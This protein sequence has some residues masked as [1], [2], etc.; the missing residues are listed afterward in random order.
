MSLHHLM[1][2][3]RR[4]EV[5]GDEISHFS[6]IPEVLKVTI[7]LAHLTCTYSNRRA[8][9]MHRSIL[10][11]SDKNRCLYADRNVLILGLRFAFCDPKV[12]PSVRHVP[13]QKW[14][15]SFYRNKSGTIISF[16]RLALQKRE[17]TFDRSAST[18][19]DSEKTWFVTYRS[20]LRALTQEQPQH[21]IKVWL[22][23]GV[24]WN[25]IL[26]YLSGKTT[27]L[28]QEFAARSRKFLRRVLQPTFSVVCSKNLLRLMILW[29]NMVSVLTHLSKIT[30]FTKQ[31]L[32]VM[33]LEHL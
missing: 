5:A 13:E 6:Q 22:C 2:N 8:T 24:K 27:S 17:S 32:L 1:T 7:S 20:W 19:Q 25:V 28:H 21:C 16:I 4:I 30:V 26:A 3:H 12:H 23:K 31:H 15:C 33:K 9:I 11:R 14:N 10:F 29:E 18:F